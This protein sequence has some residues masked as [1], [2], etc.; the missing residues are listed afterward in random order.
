MR[1]A[2]K[3]IQIL[4]ME[5]GCPSPLQEILMTDTIQNRSEIALSA[6]HDELLRIANDNL[7]TLKYDWAEV[8]RIYKM[9]NL[10]K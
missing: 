5:K 1:N 7:L 4:E 10:N 6:A 9:N 8:Y 2:K 3:T